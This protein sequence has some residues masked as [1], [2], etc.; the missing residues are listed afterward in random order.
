MNKA[1]AQK[2]APRQRTG[3]TRFVAP[4]EAARNAYL[5]SRRLDL[6]QLAKVFETAPDTVDVCGRLPKVD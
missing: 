4:Q 1:S 5:A 6:S 2:V 3:A